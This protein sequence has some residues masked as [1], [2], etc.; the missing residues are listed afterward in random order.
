MINNQDFEGYARLK[1]FSS[2]IAQDFF[3][4]YMNKKRFEISDIKFLV[5]SGALKENIFG[6]EV[7]KIRIDRCKELGWKNCFL[8]PFQDNFF[9]D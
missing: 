9:D 5:D 3:W 2:Q 7:S 8:E 6:T 4:K 1:P